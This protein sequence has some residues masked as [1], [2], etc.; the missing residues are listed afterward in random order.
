[1]LLRFDAAI[2]TLDRAIAR[3][4]NDADSLF[5]RARIR[6]E[7]D[8]S[9]P[10]LIDLQAAAEADPHSQA[11][12]VLLLRQGKLQEASEA[13]NALPA[14]VPDLAAWKLLTQGC[15]D[16]LQ[17]AAASASP[18]FPKRE[19]VKVCVEQATTLEKLI[20]LEASLPRAPELCERVS[21]L[22]LKF[23]LAAEDKADSAS[24]V[25]AYRHALDWLPSNTRA[26]FNLAA[27]YIGDSRFDQAESEYRALLAADPNDRESQFWLAQIILVTKPDAGRKAEAC[28][29]LEGA[30]Q[31]QD[32]AKRDQFVV[33]ATRNCAH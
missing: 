2:V 13:F 29:L 27:L 10:A 25:T 5:L 6:E 8:L 24:A 33:V 22:Y 3:S 23:G 26:R 1:M 16:E 9:A 31:I 19:A 32:P 7:L 21:N 18:L 4:P 12:A 17:R 20:A 14:A 15:S 30:I 11:A 28:A